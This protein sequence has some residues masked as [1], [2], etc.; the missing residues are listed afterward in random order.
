MADTF[1]DVAFIYMDA[2]TKR[3]SKSS[4]FVVAQPQL[5]EIEPH[6]HRSE[7]NLDVDICRP[8]IDTALSLRSS[9]ACNSLSQKLFG[10]YDSLFLQAQA[11]TLK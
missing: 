6:H 3:T 10:T 8:L 5:F 9:D 2:A 1:Q 4:K 11:N 7:P